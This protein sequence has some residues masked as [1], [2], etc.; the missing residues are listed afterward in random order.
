MGM[1]LRRIA[2]V[3]IA[4]VLGGAVTP[5]SAESP[6]FGAG[7]G[8]WTHDGVDAGNSGY[9]PAE[10]IVNAGNVGKLKQ[11]WSVTPKPGAEG[12][13]PALPAPLVVGGLAYVLDGDGVTALDVGTGRKVWRDAKILDSM[14]FRRIVFSDGMLVVAGSSCYANSDPD[15]HLYALDAASGR[16]LWQVVQEPPV[17]DL[18]VDEGTVVTSGWATM[19]NE[20]TVIGYNGFDGAKR[21][22]RTGATLAGPVSAGGR[23]LLHDAKGTTA[24]TVDAGRAVWRSRTRWTPLAASGSTFLAVPDPVGQGDQ[25]GLAA[26]RAG[27]GG[28]LWRHEDGADAVSTDGRRVYAVTGDEVTA[29]HANKGT[30]LWTRHLNATAGKPVRA[31]GLLYVT[32]EQRPTAILSPVDGDL[33]ADRFDR[34]TGHVVVSGGRLYTTDGGT[35]RAYGP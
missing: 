27:N 35:L 12:C 25:S 11:R 8:D 22:T 19:T 29:F 15:G 31:G 5:A 30:T 9:N 23:A 3:A 13:A 28:I 2:V 34:A 1:F 32:V 16:R 33:V 10:R 26:I 20:D 18:V 17:N 4:A 7:P 6:P 21:W 14:D 24:V